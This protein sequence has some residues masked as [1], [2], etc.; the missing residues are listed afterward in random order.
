M[1]VC[2][3][4]E[5]QEGVTWD[6][7]TALARAC[8]ELGFTGLFRSDHYLSFDHPNE[9][10]A[11]DA[12]TTLATLASITERIRLGTLVSPVTFRHP[13]QVAK[14]LV[15]V[16][17]ASGGRVELGLGAGWFEREHRA[18]GFAFPD[19]DERMAIL[20][21]QLEI[22]HR[23]WDVDEA[24]VSFEGRHYRLEECPGLPKPVQR[25]HPPLIMGGGAG[26]RSA[27]LA[28]RWADE[29]DVFS[30]APQEAAE[31]RARIS[32]AC[33][34]IDRD[35][36]EVRFSVMTTILVG[37]DRRELERRAAAMMGDDE[38]DDPASFLERMRATKLVGTPEEVL[39]RVG[40]YAAAGVRRIYL[41]DLLHDDME[42]VE[43]IGREIVPR[44]LEL[45]G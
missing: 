5:G 4:I 14:S 24:T 32:A 8:E 35:P 40:E 45:T 7:W 19:P 36:N 2:L 23:L 20:G 33:E 28:A 41:Q 29:Y 1:D 11:L 39:E 13:A 27:A 43:L 9:R 37:A 31:R 25:P 44:A 26:P 42:M 3:M 34:A 38:D 15:T 30:V 22:V 10:G 21:E 18:Y 6:R 17:H 12:W 16:D